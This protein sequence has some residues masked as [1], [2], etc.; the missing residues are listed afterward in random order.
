MTL[1]ILVNLVILANL[2]ILVKTDD[3]GESYIFDES[4]KLRDSS[5]Y[6]EFENSGEFGNCVYYWDSGK[7]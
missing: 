6:S 5:D 3:S 7:W 2:M 1:L 4:N